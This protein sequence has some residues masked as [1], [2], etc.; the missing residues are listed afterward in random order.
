MYL[1]QA[2][3]RAA[4]VT[5][6]A[7]AI[8]DATRTQNWLETKE[9]IE[10][11]A[12]ALHSL[13][14]RSGDRIAV[15]SLNSRRYVELYFAVLWAGAV[16][17]PMNIRWS[18]AEHVYSITD[19][20][21]KTLFIDDMFADAGAAIRARC[22]GLE[23]LVH[24]GEGALP[25][26][27]VSYEALLEAAHPASDAHRTGDDLA[28]IFYTGGTTGVAKGVM[29]SHLGLWTS[30]VSIGAE[31]RLSRGARYLHAAPMFHLADGAMTYAIT[32]F[33][34]AHIVMPAFD[35]SAFLGVVERH[36]VTHAL[37]V[38]TMIR[39][40]LDC[41]ELTKCD[42]SS[43]TDLA[44]GA[45][46]MAEAVLR[47][48]IERLPH[49]RLLQAY[50]QTELS[51]L[52]SILGPEWHTL[53]GPMAGKLRSAGRPGLC[54][55]AKIA[56]DAG[57]EQQ[58]GVVGEIWVRG[59]NT[60]LGY[61]NKPEQTAAALVDG[62]VRTG[63]GGRMD[64]DGFIYIVD[65]IKDMIVS[66]GENVYSAEVENAL[67]QH[68]AVAECAVIGVPDETWGERVHAIVVS[69]HPVDEADLVAHCKT[70]IAGYK[71][72]RSVEV[73]AEPLPKSGAGKILKT[74][75]REPYWIDAGRNVN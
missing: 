44:Y 41:P 67:M 31:L 64:D 15:L 28:G 37:L 58:R 54:V 63:D 18:L 46:P 30:S 5:P 50:G 39:L 47:E 11:M 29:L 38:P 17:V 34:G 45:S 61:W 10:R 26:G 55:E 59:P 6:D 24:M 21:A 8:I 12:G 14:V 4:A 27:A 40:L 16:I 69:R 53:E 42:T 68:P 32:V 65:R 51:P 56:D 43:W 19:S 52:C 48:L 66:G 3:H 70:L 72:P 36:R 35:A 75:L 7:P 1:T 62:W 2:V 57:V 71:C 74:I 33:G 20:G 60:M 25:E 22:G 9:R 49:V 73:R 13:G 23:H